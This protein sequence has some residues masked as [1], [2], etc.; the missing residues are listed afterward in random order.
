MTEGAKK[1]Y[2]SND[3]RML[4][5]VCGGLG[6]YFNTDPTIVRLLF[7]AFALVAGGGLLLYLILWLLIPQEPTAELPEAPVEE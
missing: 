1:L 4:G 7:V 2:R 5:G 6:E 3:Q